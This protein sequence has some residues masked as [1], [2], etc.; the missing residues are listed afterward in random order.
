MSAMIINVERK[1]TYESQSSTLGLL[2]TT[3]LE[4]LAAFE[5]H[6]HLIL[7]HSTF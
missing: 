6:L 1:E 4:V 3:Q 2:F 5:C 7:A